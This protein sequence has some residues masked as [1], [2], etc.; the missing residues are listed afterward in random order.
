MPADLVLGPDEWRAAFILNKKPVLRH[1][2][3]LSTVVCLIARRGG[4]LG[5][6]HD[7]KPGARTI[8]LGMQEIA[9]FVKGAH[10]FRQFNDG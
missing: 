7:G 3:T 9:A 2:P 4:F 8:W 10:Y 6:K 5:R 1:T